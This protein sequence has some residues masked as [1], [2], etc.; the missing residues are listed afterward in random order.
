VELVLGKGDYV[1]HI[2]LSSFQRSSIDISDGVREI[3]MDRCTTLLTVL[4]CRSAGERKR[5]Q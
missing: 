1:G 2:H 5:N 3:A 4:L